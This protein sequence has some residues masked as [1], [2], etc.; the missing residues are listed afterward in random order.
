MTTHPTAF[1]L[2]KTPTKPANFYEVGKV[3]VRVFLDGVAMWMRLDGDPSGKW[4][5]RTVAMQPHHP[6]Q[7]RYEIVNPQGVTVPAAIE[8]KHFPDKVLA[9]MDETLPKARTLWILH[10]K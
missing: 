4:Y 8:R 7:E 6:V 1:N 5:K 9:T 10:K 2:P 3:Q